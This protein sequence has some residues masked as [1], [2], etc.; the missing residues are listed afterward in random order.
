M[1]RRYGLWVLALGLIATAAPADAGSFENA[2]RARW[3]GA[4]I[5]TE[6]ETYSV[7][8]GN[9]FN[10]DVSGQFVAARAGR[11]FQPGELAKVDK[12]QVNRKKIELMV[13]IAGMNLVSRQD[14]PFTLYDRRTC[15]IELEVAIPR[16]VI[17]SKNVEEVDRFLAAVAQRFSTRDAALDSS[18]WNGRE[19]D[20]YPE[21]YE[22][23]LAHHAVWSA[24]EINRG[25]D[26]QLDRSLLTANELAREVDGNLI[27]LAGF[28]EGAR[29][30][31]EWRERD[32]GRLIGS[33]A[34]TFRLN[35]PEEFTDN[36]TWCAGFFD[37]QALVYNLAVLSRLPACYVDVPE[38]PAEYADTSLAQR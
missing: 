9:Y 32:C 38:L 12:L 17:K 34:G 28:A 25:I 31:R 2:V 6:I 15:K 7:C 16:D 19:A 10:N 36:T 3:R 29:M 23:T 13:T 8:N 11:P 5:I 22:R 26:E 24:E 4:W 14:G 18:D 30:M 37:G 21:D 33:T 1:I 20:E 27:Y 35:A